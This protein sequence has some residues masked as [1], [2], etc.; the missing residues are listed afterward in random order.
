VV[1]LSE[2]WQNAQNVTRSALNR[3]DADVNG[4]PRAK[5][6]YEQLGAAE[7]QAMEQTVIE[8]YG[9]TAWDDFMQ[10][11]GGGDGTRE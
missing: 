3:A 8:R 9:E 5:T 10:A 4:L 1:K 7:R 2:L 11:I 6:R